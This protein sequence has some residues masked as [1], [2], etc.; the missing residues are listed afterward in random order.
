MKPQMAT[1]CQSKEI[2][3]KTAPSQLENCSFFPFS[4]PE[5]EPS[6]GFAGEP[7]SL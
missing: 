4:S 7:L 5:R 6:S 3:W 1:G 2:S